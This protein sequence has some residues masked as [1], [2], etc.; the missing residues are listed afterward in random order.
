M[1]QSRVSEFG[2]CQKLYIFPQLK[3]FKLYFLKEKKEE[4]STSERALLKAQAEEEKEKKKEK[5][6]EET[7]VDKSVPAPD[8]EKDTEE[9]SS[10]RKPRSRK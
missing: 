5:E 2:R 3:F 8:A 7:N 4:L 6:K 10:K 9:D 1:R